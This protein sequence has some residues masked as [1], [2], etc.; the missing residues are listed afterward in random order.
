VFAP[1]ANAHGT[2]SSFER[3]ETNDILT[4]LPHRYPFL[5]VDRIIDM[6]GD[7][8]ATGIKNVTLNEPYFQ[9]QFPHRLVMPMTLLLEGMAQTAGALCMRHLAVKEPPLIYFMGIDK[10]RL[11]RPVRPGDI[12]HYRVEEIRSR[13]LI[14][15]YRER[16]LLTTSLLLGPNLAPHY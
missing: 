8:S 13:G 2:Q 4:L 16:R 7:I 10:A 6:N 14:W 1:L 15:R 9:G 3:M 12:V 5:L 11:R